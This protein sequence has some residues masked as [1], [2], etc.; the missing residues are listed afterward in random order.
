[1]EV[2]WITESVISEHKAANSSVYSMHCLSKLQKGYR[3]NEK[4]VL[5]GSEAINITCVACCTGIWASVDGAWFIP[6]SRCGQ[7]MV[8]C[9]P[10]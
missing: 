2:R 1:M 4:A 10:D 9:D 5:S 3:V 8:Y 7:C 6:V